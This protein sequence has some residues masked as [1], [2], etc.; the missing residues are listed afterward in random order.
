MENIY[1]S[2]MDLSLK[3][4]DRLAIELK[5]VEFRMNGPG[6]GLNGFCIPYQWASLFRIIALSPLEEHLQCSL[7]PTTGWQ[8]RYQPAGGTIVVNLRKWPTQY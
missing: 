7:L 3:V 5:W 8:F 4:W 6:L 1:F 2:K